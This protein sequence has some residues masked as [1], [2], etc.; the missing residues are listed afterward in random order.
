MELENIMNVK[1]KNIKECYICGR[2]L[3]DTESKLMAFRE[4][5]RAEEKVDKTMKIFDSE[6]F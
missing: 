1:S 3:I 5:V 2:R 6:N 4:Q